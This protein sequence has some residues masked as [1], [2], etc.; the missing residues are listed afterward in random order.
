ML[1]EP[2]VQALIS[3]NRCAVGFSDTCFI[4]TR[5]L[6]LFH[7][8]TQLNGDIQNHKLCDSQSLLKGEAYIPGDSHAQLHSPTP[9][10]LK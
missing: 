8:Q 10:H 1:A 5:N 7:T 4:R 6:G 2:E 3:G 9:R